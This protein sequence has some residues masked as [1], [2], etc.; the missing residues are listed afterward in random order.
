MILPLGDSPNPRGVPL[1]TYAVV[2]A[3]VAVYVLITVPLSNLGVDPSDPT[4]RE[5]VHVITDHLPHGVSAQEILTDTSAYT[6]FVFRYGFRPAAPH[7]ANLFYSLFLHAGFLHLFGN[8]LFLWIYGDNVEHRLGRIGYLIAYLGTGVAATLFHAVF[9]PDSPLPLVG[10]SGAIS[11]ILGFYFLFFPRNQVRL[12]VLLFPFFMDVFL[13]PARWVLGAYL[14]LDNLLPFLLTRGFEGGGVAYG[15]HI[16]GFIAGLA[17]AWFMDRRELSE[18]PSEY[19]RVA[20]PEVE[21]SA[22]DAL[23]SALADGRMREAAQIYFALAPHAT[24]RLLS[25]QELLALGDWLRRNGHAEAALVVFRRHLRDY[26]YG[27]DAAEAHLGAGLVL[28]EA[29]N[30]PTPAYQHFLEAL[31]LNPP[32]SVA[33]QIRA[34]LA[35]IAARQKFQ[36]GHP[37]NRG[38]R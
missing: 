37:Y 4:L 3:N 34:A 21:A 14:L 12:L 17:V 16:G 8:M 27:A 5:Y 20:T 22:E 1:V 2:A 28:L 35:A 19:R 6:L 15:A 25:P 18:R 9:D 10:A 26:P 13:V 24:R 30:E 33:A 29:F 38:S 32:P 7:V 11:G 23:R 31:D 36:I